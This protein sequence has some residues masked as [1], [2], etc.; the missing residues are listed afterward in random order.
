MPRFD[1]TATRIDGLVVIRRKPVGDDRGF[2]SRLFCE[3]EFAAL[4][5]PMRT[6]QIN[7]TMT[8]RSGTIRGM[9]AIVSGTV[10]GI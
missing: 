7:H 8:R 3:E 9:S 4:G 6:C 10:D 5:I 2:L 1:V